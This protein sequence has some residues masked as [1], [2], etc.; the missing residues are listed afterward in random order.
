MWYPNRLVMRKALNLAYKRLQAKIWCRQRNALTLCMCVGGVSRCS[1]QRE[2]PVNDALQGQSSRGKPDC[3]RCVRVCE[4][5]CAYVSNH[6]HACEYVYGVLAHTRSIWV[7]VTAYFT[8]LF[9]HTHFLSLS[10]YLT[11]TFYVW[12]H[13]VNCLE[14]NWNESWQWMVDKS[15]HPD[16]LFP[17]D[18][19][20][21]SEAVPQQR[22]S[23][24]FWF[25]HTI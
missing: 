9:W 5:V 11:H 21:S 23:N 6:P 2:C 12:A 17:I 22:A 14:G 19:G 20:L 4:S 15:K 25:S 3:S 13:T 8:H 7:Y 1:C 18:P 24:C 10:I 16:P